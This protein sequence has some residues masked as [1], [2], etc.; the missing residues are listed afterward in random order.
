MS[1]T[2]SIVVE[3]CGLKRRRSLS[4]VCTGTESRQLYLLRYE[5]ETYE[6]K[7]YF[8]VCGSI[9]YRCADIANFL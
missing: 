5:E 7:C 1:Y 4:T 6:K 8:T 9:A 3:P 2:V